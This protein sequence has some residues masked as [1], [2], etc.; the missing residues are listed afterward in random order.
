MSEPQ[1]PPGDAADDE[2]LVRLRAAA[3]LHDPVPDGAV[4]A[5]R[6]AIAY[7]DLDRQLAALTHDSWEHQ[8]VGTRSTT[9]DARL[10]TFEADAL[11]I[12]L[13]VADTP[14]GSRIV[15]QILPG[16]VSDLRVETEDDERAIEVDDRGRFVVTEVAGPRVRLRIDAPDGVV[17]TPWIRL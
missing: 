4:L 6:S 2:L 5:A 13:E 7:R 16:P 10:L 8:L 17:T 15:G 3:R 11:V 1:V 9:T 14:D 12:E